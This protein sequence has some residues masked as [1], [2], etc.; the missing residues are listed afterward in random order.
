[1]TATNA[2]LADQAA[3]LDALLIDAALGPVRRFTPDL[4]TVRWAT[5]LSR[6]PLTCARRVRDLASEA[7]GAVIGGLRSAR[8]PGSP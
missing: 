8:S 4:S 7:A 6:R 2:E 3:P 5:S 1:M